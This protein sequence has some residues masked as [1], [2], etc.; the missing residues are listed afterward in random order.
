[1][2]ANEREFTLV[3]KFD[4]QIT[5]K[6]KEINAELEKLGKPLKKDNATKSLKDG[7]EAANKELKTLQDQLAQINK[8]QMKFDKSG[9]QAATQE[10]KV[11]GKEIEAVS[12]AGFNFDKSGIVAAQKEAD[13]LGDI[14]KANA[15]VKVGEGFS[16]A[17]TA[18]ATSA[19]N[20]LQRGMGFIGSRLKEATNDQLEDVMARGSLFGSLQKQGMFKG[21]MDG[22][23]GQALKD[24]SN[25]MYI[26]TKNISRAMD[27]S[28]NEIIR[29]STVSSETIQILSRQLGDNLLPTLLKEKQ[30][31]DLSN[32][33]REKLNEI[34]GGEKGVGQQ[35]ANLYSQ[36]GSVIPNAGY[37]RQAGFGVTQFLGAGTINRQLAIFEQNPILVDA[38]KEGLKKFGNT[39]EGRIKA[40]AYGFS[41]AMPEAALQEAKNT[42]AGGLQSLNDTLL[43]PSGILT[44][45]ADISGQGKRTLD[46][47]TKS[48]V[49]ADEI[50]NFDRKQAE[51]LAS[52]KKQNVT[53]AQ[54]QEMETHQIAGRKRF[55]ANLDDFYQSA[56]SPIEVLATQFGPLLQSFANMINNAGNL[57]IAPVNTLVETMAPAITKLKDNFENLGS[58]LALFVKTKGLEGRS[59]GEVLGRAF[60]EIFKALAKYFN[61]E[62]AGKQI[63]EGINTFF[64]D[65]AKGFKNQKIDGEKYLRIVMDSL[66]SIL[67]KLIFKEGDVMK[68]MTGLG[69]AL[70]KVFLLLAAPAFVSALISGLIPIA[71]M[72]MG[73]LLK[74]VF[75]GL[76]AKVA[77]Q[78]A[79]K[80]AAEAARAAAAANAART[81]NIASAALG[82][83]GSAGAAG[84]GA[85]GAEAGAGAGAGAGAVAATGA[86]VT[87]AG[88]L[89]ILLIVAAL[90][91]AF[92]IFEAPL[93]ALADWLMIAGVK[94]TESKNWA[95]S[96]FGVMLQGIS[97]LLNG[98]TDFF[99]G[100]WD[101][102]SG[103]FTGDSEKI[104]RGVKK[105]FTGIGKVIVG[106][107][108][109]V[110][111]LGGVITGAIGNL[112]NAIGAAISKLKRFIPGYSEASPGPKKTTVYTSGATLV[113]HN[114]KGQP[115]YIPP[116][117][118]AGAFGSANPFMG[119][120][121]EAINFEMANKPANS[122]LVI[123][124][125]SETVI[126]AAGGFGGGMQGV[127]AAVWG[128][129]QMTTSSTARAMQASASITISH[130]GRGLEKMTYSTASSLSR[131]FG[132]L[133]RT[134][135]YGQ[136]Q[137]TQAMNHSLS[138]TSSQNQQLLSAV[139]AAA[140]AGGFGGD[141][142]GGMFGGARGSLS[143]AARIAQSLGL[144]MTS[145]RGGRHAA[146][147]YHYQGRAMDF[148]GDPGAM[149]RLA[150]S[151]SGTRPTEL[152]HAP[153]FSMK[154]GRRVSPG[155]WGA[156]TWNNHYDHV[157]VAYAL[158]KGRPA[159]FSSQVAAEAWERQMIPTSMKVRSITTN[160]GETNFGS[161]TLH[162]PITIYQQ[163]NQDPEQLASMVAIRIGM[164][165][166]ELRNRA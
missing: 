24:A 94:L 70:T 67:M 20:I 29:T 116:P 11:L 56:D 119:N 153:G 46:M 64:D 77:K 139:K 86:G 65:F 2:A 76:A 131:G 149:N 5:K 108:I 84:V 103:M 146:G 38:L 66:Q 75:K 92:V 13:V 111:G 160:S 55:I 99:T 109:S 71:L 90:V 143:G 14:L 159:L 91:A 87:L 82:A 163:P 147:S 42:I 37:A 162:A 16:N 1:M 142:D 95:A 129:A 79:G 17:L 122:H 81:A 124:N 45:T 58:D 118:G 130:L 157:H 39:V 107:I 27:N 165:V 83:G 41:I 10:V 144:T 152:I 150:A 80:A 48:G 8:F 60:A 161:T 68:G 132:Q 22:K 40:A 134:T 28:I 115:L 113:G 133:N 85:A 59:F 145:Y 72:G 127:I 69:D 44:F 88:L 4:D 98:L 62:K 47:M 128:A 50:K 141:L 96:A 140:A 9:I 102:V 164:A 21:A 126:P 30:I 35:L 155:F 151:L 54:I 121:G 52:Y 120:L 156:S 43:G 51:V 53:Q 18:G 117:V 114:D 97:F 154:N 138:V 12:K 104:I 74:G 158:G 101:I 106:L 73:G 93:R 148:G 137:I 135:A 49:R 3:G 25:D 63:G 136:S 36:I 89:S 78:T 33:S 100:I 61:P 112:F 19:V 7:F 15:L 23:E 166:D 110:V 26:Q 125:S 123:A 6:L 31:T 105:L 57:F 32:V 34:M